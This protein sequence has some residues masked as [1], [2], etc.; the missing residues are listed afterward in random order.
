[1]AALESAAMGKA[2][3]LITEHGHTAYRA[4]QVAGIT[5]SAI[6]MAP[7]YKAWRIAQLKGKRK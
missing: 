4:A 2:R 7:W 6:Y 5:S 1:M 3:K